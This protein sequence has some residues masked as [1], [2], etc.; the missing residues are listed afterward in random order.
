MFQGIGSSV[1]IEPKATPRIKTQIEGATN[2]I[3][4]ERVNAMNERMN[5]F[6]SKLDLIVYYKTIK[7]QNY[8]NKIKLLENYLKL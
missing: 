2:E 6:E 3:L 1:D 5:N 8:K 7:L 4:N